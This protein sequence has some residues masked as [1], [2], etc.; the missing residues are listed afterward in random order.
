M[1]THCAWHSEP[2]DTGE[3]VSSGIC[4]ACLDTLITDHEIPAAPEMCGETDDF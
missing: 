1:L 4:P 3:P 2:P